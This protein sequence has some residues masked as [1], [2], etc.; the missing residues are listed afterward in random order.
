MKKVILL[1]LL[2]TLS[3]FFAIS[4]M[5][6]SGGT[7]GQVQN[8]QGDDPDDGTGDPEP[9]PPTQPT[10]ETVYYKVMVALTN[11]FSVKGENPV[12]VAKGENA[13]FEI[14]I[15]PTHAFVSVSAGSFDPVTGILTVENVTRRM[16][17]DFTVERLAEE[18]IGQEYV[19]LF[20]GTS[21][22]SSSVSSYNK[23]SAGTTVSVRAGDMTKSFVGWSFGKS[24][25]AG[26]EIVSTERDYSFRIEESIASSGAVRIFANYSEA[27]TFYYDLMGG[28]VNTSSSNMQSGGAYYTASRTDDGRVKITLLD[29]YF[30][31]A[32]CASLFWDDGS[33]TKDGYILKEYNTRSDGSG[34]GYS[35]GSKYFPVAES[36]GAAVLYCIWEKCDDASLFGYEDYTYAKPSSVKYADSWYESGVIITSVPSS[37][38]KIVVPERIGAKPVIAIASGA[39][40]DCSVQ[41]L[42]LPKTIKRI[43]DGAFVRC[44]S[45]KTI[46]LPDSVYSISDAVFDAATYA[47]FNNLILNATM[48]PRYADAQ[49]GAFAV[50]LC[51]VLSAGDQRMIIFVAGS[52]TYQGLGTEYLEALLDGEYRVVNYGTTRTRPGYLYMEALAHYTD[53][54]DIVIFAPENSAFMLGDSLIDAR[55]L[56]DLEGVNNLYRYIDFSK[57]HGYFTALGGFNADRYA[58]KATRYEDICNDKW[59]NKYGDYLNSRRESFVNESSYIDAYIL[60]FNERIKS[61][62][63]G[64]WSTPNQE[65]WTS[66]D[67]ED[68]LYIINS[69]ID[70]V[71]ATGAKVYFAFAPADANAIVDEARSADK[72]DEYDA[73]IG[74]VYNLDGLLG[75]AKDYVYDHKYFY[76]CAYHVN[77]YGRTYRTY[78]LY[79]DLAEKLG[80]DF[81]KGIYYEGTSFDGCRFEDGSDG[82]PLTKVDY[83][84]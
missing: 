29:K 79:L 51:R 50:K 33:F 21:K 4:C 69:A 6:A 56:L 66:L 48:A 84:K 19:Y 11:G 2:L 74:E 63:E 12:N 46:Y 28:S 5:P 17:V 18:E 13:V 27:N 75:S 62:D 30:S 20:S 77:D 52:S 81:T 36:G 14:E 35:L 23:V 76:D 15:A 39:F 1:L 49:Y 47:S 70:K 55:M 80:Y 57:Y 43:E 65:A 32:G 40:S 73:L 37:A 59:S 64:Q 71:K 72:L 16:T 44:T 38:E 83:L 78:M 7:G 53:E 31:Y 3:V 42:I 9:A 58:K 45:L 26:G 22:D 41:T 60:T 61:I 54:S 67:R 10:E 68:Y 82:T 25:D 24:A 8:D 34:E